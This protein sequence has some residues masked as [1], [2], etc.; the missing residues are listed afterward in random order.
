MKTTKH[1]EVERFVSRFCNLTR[2]HHSISKRSQ[3]LLPSVLRQIIYNELPKRDNERELVVRE[4]TD[5]DNIVVHH[6]RKL[7]DLIETYN[8]RQ[9]PQWVT[10]MKN[11]RRKSLIVCPKC[12]KEIHNC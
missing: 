9:M 5:S 4:F 3:R 7:Y 10:I 11:I 12:H 8:D 2:N 1:P 6:I